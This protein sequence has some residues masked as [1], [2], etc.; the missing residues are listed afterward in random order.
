LRGRWF[1]APP[2]QADPASEQRAL[3]NQA[4]ALQAELDRIKS[5]LSETGSGGRQE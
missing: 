3:T 5:R 4:A 1:A 2:Q